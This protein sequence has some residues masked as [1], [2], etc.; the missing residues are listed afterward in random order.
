MSKRWT[1]SLLTIPGREEYLQRLLATL[2]DARVE[3]HAQID[4]V[5]NWDAREAPAEIEK[6]ILRH[7]KGLPVRVSFNTV[8]PSI[9]SGRAQ[10]L[11]ACRTP[12]ICFVDDDISVHGDLIGTFENAL[13]S[14][15]LSIVGVR[16][17]VNET[18]E[19]FKPRAS[20]PHVTRGN[21]RFMTVQGMAIAGYRRLFLD[22]GGF[23]PRRRFWGEWT[24]LNL[25]LWRRGF[26]TAYAMDGA[27]LRHWH[28]APN[29]PTRNRS[30][31]EAEV[32]WGLMCTALEYDAVDINQHTESFWKLVADRYLPYSFGPEMSSQ[33]LLSAT[34]GLASRLTAE[35]GRIQEF[36]E[37]TRAHPFKFAPFASIT[38]RD[39]DAVLAHANDKIQPYRSEVWPETPRPSRVRRAIERIWGP[40]AQVA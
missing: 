14:S 8:D 39:V 6:K 36:R 28:N 19:L 7:G 37:L 35:W 21:M 32:L 9:V 24:E 3:R 23:N 20:T 5:Y 25:R 27:F 16:S 33:A 15:P 13:Q 29:S 34:L 30:G 38:E 11:N 10:Q 17:Y 31:R 4:V 40:Q 18:S 22:V 2:A 12:L 1:I 26:P